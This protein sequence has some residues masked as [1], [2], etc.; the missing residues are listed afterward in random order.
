M[1]PGGP[2]LICQPYYSA[3]GNSIME[4]EIYEGIE[5]FMYA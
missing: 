2:E 4:R 1:L 3:T 5:A